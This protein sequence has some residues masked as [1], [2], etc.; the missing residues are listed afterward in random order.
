MA[1]RQINSSFHQQRNT[2]MFFLPVYSKEDHLENGEVFKKE[3]KVMYLNP[4]SFAINEQKLIKPTMTKGGY[5]VQYWGEEL[6]KITANGT[7]GSAGIE[8][9][10]VL[11]D[12][13]R[14][15]Q[16]R[17][18]DMLDKRRADEELRNKVKVAGGGNLSD[19]VTGLGIIDAAL[20]GLG[21]RVVSGASSIMDSF[22]E[23]YEEESF[24]TF[25][26]PPSLATFATSIDMYYQGEIFR[27][28][29]TTFSYNETASEPGH[30]TY[31]FAF[32]VTRR[33]GERLNFMPWHKNPLNADGTTRKASEPNTGFSGQD[34]LVDGLINSS[35]LERTELSF[36]G[37]G[38]QNLSTAE[39]SSAKGVAVNGK[40]ERDSKA[41]QQPLKR[42]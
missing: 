20:G 39:D 22:R 40:S 34:G 38:V 36:K 19:S 41:G 8:G 1:T 16:I 2:I 31:Q 9:I 3:V 28:F 14:H 35:S 11:R 29:F 6:T 10:N 4:Q 15:E 7:T 21:G 18:R 23:P 32:T 17:F 26:L 42:R 13:Y 5:T 27:G 12:I 24:D 30:F 33:S 25:S 37:M